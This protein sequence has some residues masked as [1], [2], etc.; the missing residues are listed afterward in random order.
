MKQTRFLNFVAMAVLILGLVLAG[1]SAV[2]PVYAGTGDQIPHQFES[3][4]GW[5]GQAGWNSGAAMTETPS[6]SGSYK[7]ETSN[8]ATGNRYFRFWNSTGSTKYGPNGGSD[9]QLSLA[10]STGLQSWGGSKA[11]YVNV[12][13]TSYK[14]VFKTAGSGAPGTSKVIV[15]EIQDT[16]RSVSSTSRTPSGTVCPGEAVTVDATLDGSLS[17]GQAVYLRYSTDNFSTSTVVKL[18]GSGTSY[19]ASIPSGTNTAENTVWYYLFTSGDVSSISGSDAN[20][21]T[22]NLNNNGG[23]NYSYTVAS[24]WA[25]AA[26]GNWNTAGTWTCGE[27]PADDQTIT[28]AHDVTLDKDAAVRHLVINSSKTLTSEASTARTLT[29]KSGSMFLN[30]GAFTANDG[31]VSFA[32]SG[33]V[34]GNATTFNHVTIAGGVNFDSSIST[35]NGTLQ[36]NSGG[37][38]NTNPPIYGASSTLKYN[39]N[40][41]YGRGLEWSATSGAGYP[42]N[43][44]ISNNT[45]LN[46]PN[47]STAA[48]SMAGSLTIDSGSALYMDYGAPGLNN[49]LTVGGDVTINGALS[50]GDASGGDLNVGGDWTLDLAGSFNNNDREV[51]FNGPLFSVQTINSAT[52]W[53]YL[54]IDKRSSLSLAAAQTVNNEIPRIHPDSPSH[55][56]VRLAETQ[57]VSQRLRLTNGLLILGA[58]TLT[59]S[60]SASVGGTPSASAMVVTDD[61]AG[62]LCKTYATTGSFTFPI[63]DITG[64]AEYSPMDLNVT[65][66]S[67]M[68]CLNVT[69]A[70][71]PYKPGGATSYIDRYWTLSSPT[72]LS[73]TTVAHPSKPGSATSY[74]DRYWPGSGVAVVSITGYNA[75]LTFVDADKN[76][77]DAMSGKKWTGAYPFETLGAVSGNQFSTGAQTTFS[78]FTAFDTPLAAPLSSL[79]ATAVGGRIVVAWETTSELSSQG[80]HVYRADAAGGDWTRLNAA[81]IPS[82]APGSPSGYGYRWNDAGVARGATYRYLVAAVGLDG[83]EEALETVSVT[84]PVGWYWLPAVAQ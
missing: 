38:V 6:G 22:I 80:Y 56:A 2:A 61:S 7:F 15:F 44:Q 19:S 35:V 52:D 1:L 57:T 21:Y 84:M 45:T 64:T 65:G 41:T 72:K 79:N 12:G 77:A 49:P 59:L 53:A 37:Y 48:R 39:S 69:N 18:T 54:A 11:Y 17:T 42:A 29:L 28:I 24:S 8:S 63:G 68:A 62:M 60:S 27:V 78:D 75:T 20:Y 58:N 55:S 32:G 50:L 10:T 43:V 3:G 74:I 5:S 81:M 31:T 9:I 76:G 36:I 4:D 40:T 34:S 25:T 23:S 30:N 67:G 16:V 66:G 70:V 26:D 73:M 14:Y 13:S 51:V 33:T 82:Q 46:Y 47:G 83:S 71:H